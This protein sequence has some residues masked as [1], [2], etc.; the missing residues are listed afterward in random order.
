MRSLAAAEGTIH[1][2][3]MTTRKPPIGLVARLIW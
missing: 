3:R 2:V 1:T